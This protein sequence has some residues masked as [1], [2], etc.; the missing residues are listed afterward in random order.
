ML[1][2]GRTPRIGTIEKSKNR[3]IEA[4]YISSSIPRFLKYSII[5]YQYPG[6]CCAA[7]TGLVSSS[8]CGIGQMNR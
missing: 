6:F 7:N 4:L 8:D 5:L 2:D 3:G 1:T